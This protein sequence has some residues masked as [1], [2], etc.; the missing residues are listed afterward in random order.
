[1]TQIVTLKTGEE[2][3][4]LRGRDGALVVFVD[5]VEGTGQVRLHLN[6]HMVYGGDPEVDE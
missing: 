6:E 5:T 2:V 1:M 4:V 3:S